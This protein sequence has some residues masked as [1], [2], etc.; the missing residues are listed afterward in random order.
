LQAVNGASE[1]SAQTAAR[2]K[3]AYH[4]EIMQTYLRVGGKA[5]NSTVQVCDLCRNEVGT[6]RKLKDAVCI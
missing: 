4:L 6:L 1:A 2:T 5:T 3:S